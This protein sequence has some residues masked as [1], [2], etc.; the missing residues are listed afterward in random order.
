MFISLLGI[1]IFTLLLMLQLAI[2]SRLP[3]LQGTADLMLLFVIAWALHERV[4]H[5]W[6]WT[7]IGGTLV[8]LVSAT[9][10]FVP[11]IAYLIATAIGRLL[12]RQVWQ[13]P[14]LAM[15]LMTF[16][17]TILYHG[18]TYLALFFNGTALPIQES[19]SLVTLPST[20][21]NL[22]FALPIFVIVNDLA[23]WVYPVEVI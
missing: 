2:V 23:H 16:V 8:S 21:L 4:K 15:L 6:Q 5:A 18:I 1:P 17:A 11:L 22:I 9:P 12:Q 19:I 14:I 13:T 20:L 7:L 10:F 3:L